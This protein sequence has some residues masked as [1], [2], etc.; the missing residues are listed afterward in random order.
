M[1]CD[2]RAVRARRRAGGG[3]DGTADTNV[4]WSAAVLPG[5]RV[6]DAVAMCFFK[7]RHG[8]RL[9]ARVAAT[10]GVELPLGQSGPA[11]LHALG[12]ATPSAAAA[13]AH[14]LLLA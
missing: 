3:S 5:A 2:A 12:V 9:T 7:R 8:A 11:W 4:T 10:L 1:G 14:A 6:G 13:E